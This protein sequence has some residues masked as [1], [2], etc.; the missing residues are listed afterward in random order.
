MRRLRWV[1]LACWAVLGSMAAQAEE[2][3]DSLLA[4]SW[5]ENWDRG[6]VCTPS[7]ANFTMTLD[8]KSKTLVFQY[9]REVQSFDG[10]KR[11]A[12]TYF[13]REYRPRSL[14]LALDGETRKGDS[15][16]PVEWELI[17][18]GRGIYRWRAT[19]WP[20]REV[21]RIIGVRCSA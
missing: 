16:N 5:Q 20:N 18:V 21:N 2:S 12:L 10:Q 11:T 19:E 3:I 6:E 17:F 15:G 8:R 7:S 1:L 14:V 4:G 9:D 13:V